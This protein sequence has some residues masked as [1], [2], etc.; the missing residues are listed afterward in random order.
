[1]QQL[2]PGCSD[3]RIIEV[4]FAVFDLKVIAPGNLSLH[5]LSIQGLFGHGG[6]LRSDQDVRN[7]MF[8]EC[9]SESS[10]V[11]ASRHHRG[12][13]E[14]AVLSTWQIFSHQRG[15]IL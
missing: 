10:S 8:F 4:H 15:D 14:S 7:P 3:K 5:V 1:M 13:P 11:E 6:D 9:L 2:I 12:S